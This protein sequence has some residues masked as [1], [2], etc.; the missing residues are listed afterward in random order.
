MRGRNTVKIVRKPSAYRLALE[1]LEPTHHQHDV[2]REQYAH[3]QQRV[4]MRGLGRQRAAQSS[5]GVDQRVEGRSD[6]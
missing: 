6:S 2:D 1:L 4:D 3:D 5:A